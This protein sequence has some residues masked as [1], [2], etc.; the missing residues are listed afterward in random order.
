MILRQAAELAQLRGEVAQLKATVEAWARRLARHSRNASQPPST[1]PPPAQ[2]QRVRREAS[3]RRPG[4]PPGHAGQA[5]ALVP[6]EAVEVV[7]PLKPVR[8][9]RGQHR[10][11]GED[12]R[13]ARQQVTALP[14]V[15]PVIT[16]SQWPRVVGPA[17]GAATRAV[18]P[19][20]LPTG[21]CGPRV[22]AIPALGTGASQL[23]HRPPQTMLA[24]LCGVS[25]GLG[26]G[27]NLE[28]ATVQ[29]LAEPVAEARALVPAP[30]T[31][32]LDETG[33]REGPQ[34]AWLW[35]MVTTGG[36]VFVVRRSRGAKVARAL[37]G[38]RFWGW[39]GTDRWSASTWSP[40]WRR[41]L[42]WAQLQRD[43][44][45]MI[46]RGGRAQELGEALGAQVRLRCQWWPRVRAGTLAQTRVAS[47]RRPI[48]QEGERR[49]E[50]G[51]P[52]GAPT[53][54]GTCREIL[55]MRQAWGTCGRHE[56]GEPTNNTA[57]RAIRPGVRW[58]TGS[59]G[60]QSPDGSR[61]VETRRTVVATLK[62]HHRNVLD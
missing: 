58:R 23:S 17:C 26:T 29:V 11:R 5:R 54:E 37:W 28:Q 60:T 15:R 40:T 57:E 4:G 62:P 59:C 39:L 35:T 25:I 6:V 53:T 32:D 12:P 46:D 61:C 52:C 42:W 47:S 48:R 27:A 34:R 36:T 41:Q 49:L 55:T 50:A 16:A 8:G 43:I 24:D 10:V 51:Q 38:E 3:G 22:Q 44:A 31:A 1:D 7:I 21:G 2:S 20:G 30:P 45:A 18:G 19:V 33:G 56:G 14:P 13:P 9:T